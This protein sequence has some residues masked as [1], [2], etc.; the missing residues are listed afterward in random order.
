MPILL[1]LLGNG[2]VWQR[3]L[4][5]PTHYCNPQYDE[6]VTKGMRE[7]DPKTQEE[8]LQ[9][10]SKIQMHDA[11]LIPLYQRKGSILTKLK[12]KGGSPFIP[13][14]RDTIRY[15]ELSVE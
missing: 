8:L 14:I 9:S 11:P 15:S 7:K 4:W 1:C 13:N 10:A 6:L 12:M 3:L 2:N 5:N